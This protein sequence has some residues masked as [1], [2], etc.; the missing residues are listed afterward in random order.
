[1]LEGEIPPTDH[2]GWLEIFERDFA[3]AMTGAEDLL[4][5]VS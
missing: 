2:K 5:V 3:R 1:M 4:D